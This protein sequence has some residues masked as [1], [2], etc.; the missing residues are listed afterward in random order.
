MYAADH[1]I[2]RASHS[3]PLT[4]FS[5]RQDDPS[6]EKTLQAM[7]HATIAHLTS[8]FRSWYHHPSLLGEMAGP[9]L[10]DIKIEMRKIIEGQQSK[11]TFNLYSCHDVTLLAILYAV[12]LG[13]LFSSEESLTT[14][15]NTSLID[16]KEDR[17]TRWPNYA[18]CLTFELIRVREPVKEDEFIVKLWMNEPTIPEFNIVSIP[19]TTSL[20]QHKGDMTISDFEGLVYNINKARAN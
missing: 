3:V 8:R 15:L 10:N 12:R 17:F 6:A 14:G 1:F 13:G 5:H 19:T 20:S 18:T 4:Q 7:S 2:C 16:L 9:A 11:N